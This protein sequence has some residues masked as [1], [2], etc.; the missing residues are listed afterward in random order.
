MYIFYNLLLDSID[1]SLLLK[2]LNM[3]GNSFNETIL[4]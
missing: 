2:L 4:N 1:D 3:M